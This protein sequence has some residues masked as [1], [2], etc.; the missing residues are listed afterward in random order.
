MKHV[1]K[2]SV[3]FVF[4][5]KNFIIVRLSLHHKQHSAFPFDLTHLQGTLLLRLETKSL[6]LSTVLRWDFVEEN[7]RF[8]IVAVR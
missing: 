4:I 5:K 2:A 7:L 1:L 3:L 6:H 8:S